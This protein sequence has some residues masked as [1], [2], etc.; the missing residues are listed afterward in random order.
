MFH[1]DARGVEADFF[2]DGGMDLEPSEEGP[3]ADGEATVGVSALGVAS[4][5]DLL[6]LGVRGATRAVD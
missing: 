2:A 6:L 3:F 5:F 4:F 1:M